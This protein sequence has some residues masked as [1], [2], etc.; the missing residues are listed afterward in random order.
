MNT[1]GKLLLTQIAADKV[2][3]T[4]CFAFVYSVVST[5]GYIY[6]YTNVYIYMLYVCVLDCGVGSSMLNCYKWHG[7]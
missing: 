2:R 4:L 1:K 5:V 7:A 3:T 6:T